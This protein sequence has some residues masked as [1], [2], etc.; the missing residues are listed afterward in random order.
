MTTNSP[1]HIASL[2]VVMIFALLAFGSVDLDEFVHQMETDI[3]PDLHPGGAVPEGNGLIIESGT[4]TTV[5]KNAFKEEHAERRYRFGG[6]ITDVTSEDVAVVQ[7]GASHLGTVTFNHSVSHLKKGQYISFDATILSFGSS[8][9]S[10]ITVNH[11][12]GGADLVKSGQ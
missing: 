9:G 7:L 8:F 6:I 3:Q 1:R 4:G 2:C 5:K 12:L 11:K 10:G